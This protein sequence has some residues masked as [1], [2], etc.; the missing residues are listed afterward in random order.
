MF[1]R[2][3]STE[4]GKRQKLERRS[5]E[6][7]TKI[8]YLSVKLSDLVFLGLVFES[9]SFVLIEGERGSQDKKKDE[10]RKETRKE[11]ERRKKRETYLVSKTLNV[12]VDWSTHVLFDVLDGRTWTLWLLIEANKD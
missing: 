8:N 1:K 4:G 2:Y 11:R 3:R 12:N 6:G 10:G 9:K 7:K 5:K